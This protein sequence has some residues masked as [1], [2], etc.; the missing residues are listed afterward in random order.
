MFWLDSVVIWVRSLSRWWILWNQHAALNSKDQVTR[1]VR[2]FAIRCAPNFL[3]GEILALIRQ[4]ANLIK[5][6]FRH[7][8][9]YNADFKFW[10][11][12]FWATHFGNILRMKTR[13]YFSQFHLYDC[14]IFECIFSRFLEISYCRFYRA[15]FR[16]HGLSVHL[17]ISSFL[18]RFS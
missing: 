18:M 1:R 16:Y 5:E 2:A 6:E 14:M 9:R 3:H 4:N 8:R 12:I 13:N 17:R 10:S 7:F 11:N 15:T